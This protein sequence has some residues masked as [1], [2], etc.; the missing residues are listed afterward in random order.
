MTGVAFG[1]CFGDT[2]FTGA[3]VFG[4]TIGT[5]SD[6]SSLSESFGA[7]AFLAPRAGDLPFGFVALASSSDSDSDFVFFLAGTCFF[8]STFPLAAGAGF[9][10]GCGSSD[11][12]SY[13]DVSF[14]L[15]LV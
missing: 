5:S 13:E 6:S 1:A 10:A 3:F 8:C 14:L 11:S 9:F 12:D 7:G 4:A 15:F 2:P